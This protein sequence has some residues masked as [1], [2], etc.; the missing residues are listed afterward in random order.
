MFVEAT[1]RLELQPRLDLNTRRE[2]RWE[3][4][5]TKLRELGPGRWIELPLGSDV[6]H[7]KFSELNRLVSAGA[8]KS[9]RI[10][11]HLHP[12]Q[13]SGFVRI[14]PDWLPTFCMACGSSLLFPGST[15]FAIWDCVC[16]FCGRCY[17]PPEFLQDA[18][19]ELGESQKLVLDAEKFIPE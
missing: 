1:M 7:E 10:E 3:K 4:L 14:V 8:R 9:L 19:K 16:S 18:P 2:H 17:E 15:Q 11:Y 13:A 6:I 5:L 12:T